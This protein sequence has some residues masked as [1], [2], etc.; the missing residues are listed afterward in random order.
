[1]YYF[2]TPESL[3]G[4]SVF[5]VK[6]TPSTDAARSALFTTSI[7]VR[8]TVFVKKY[9]DNIICIYRI[10]ILHQYVTRGQAHHNR[11]FCQ[12][13]RLTD[14]TVQLIAKAFAR[15]QIHPNSDHYMTKNRNWQFLYIS[16]EKFEVLFIPL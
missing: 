1:M 14:C 8:I 5:G 4:I 16:T 7:C 11:T 15:A 12:S 3:W 2:F 13:I 10:Y 6:P 9:I